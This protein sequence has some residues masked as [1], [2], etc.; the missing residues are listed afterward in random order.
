M[1]FTISPIHEGLEKMNWAQ[2]L[3]FNF[4]SSTVDPTSLSYSYNVETGELQVTVPYNEEL[5]N[6]VL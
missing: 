2:L 5:E 6:S 1:S 4:S 3:K